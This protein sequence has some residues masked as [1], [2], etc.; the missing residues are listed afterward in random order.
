MGSLILLFLGAIHLIKYNFDSL[1]LSIIYTIYLLWL[2]IIFAGVY[3]YFNYSFFKSAFLGAP[4]GPLLYFSPL[5]LL[6][7]RNLPSYKKLF[8][9]IIIFGIFYILYDIL[10]IKSLMSSDTSNKKNIALV[11]TL[12]T[13][14]YSCGFIIL[15]AFYHTKKRFIIALGII[16]L[17]ILFAVIRGRR[18]LILMYG[19]VLFFSYFLYFF[20]SKKK[21]LIIYASIFIGLAGAF[22]AV[23]VYRP[24]QNQIFG[25]LV[26]RGDED[27]R[28]GVELYFYDDM[29][30]KDWIVGRGI[31]GE[32]FCPD[33]EED[34]PTDFRDTIETGYLQ[35]ILNGGLISLGLFLLIAFPA[36][37]KGVFSSKNILSKAA[38]IWIFMTIINSYPANTNVFSLSYL[39]AWISIGICYSRR[40]RYMHESDL[41][42][43][44]QNQKS[45]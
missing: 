27:T 10:F 26:Q 6:F 37:I 16:L 25:F 41:E 43:F 13:L 12:S 24:K 42:N 14:S 20:K 33:I 35:T 1:Y 4:G 39:I 28:T 2:F 11:E 44:F 19:E 7:P 45:F 17:A 38:G 36:V 5:I 22:Y 34:Q 40:I 30:T 8:D 9:V 21:L 15:T 32:Y 23:H 3:K 29:K 18:G 31:K